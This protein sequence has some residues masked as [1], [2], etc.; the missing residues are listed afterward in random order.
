MAVPENCSNNNENPVPPSLNSPSCISSHDNADIFGL[1]DSQEA[2]DGGRRIVPFVHEIK[3]QGQ[4]R[5]PIQVRALFDDGA[6]VGIMALTLFNKVKQRLGG[7]G[8]SKKMLHMVNG[9]RIPSQAHWSGTVKVGG[10]TT[11]GEF[12]VFDSG[13]HWDFLFSKPLLTA[14]KAIHEYGEDRVTV[15]GLEGM[16]ILENEVHTQ[17]QNRMVGEIETELTKQTSTILGEEEKHMQVDEGIFTRHTDPFKKEHV[18][19][20]LSAVTFGLS[21]TEEQLTKAKELIQAYADCFAL[22]ISEVKAVP[23][24]VH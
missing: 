4:N 18:E 16:T 19:A 23:N 5:V 14:F 2:R 21:L 24:A 20:V 1:Y 13:G 12:E 15:L 9:E 3:L 7:W 10:I 8:P 17:A 6:M 22:A 11:H